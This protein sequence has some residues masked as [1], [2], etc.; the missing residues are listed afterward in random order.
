M[1]MDVFK[2]YSFYR[3]MKA[4]FFS[5]GSRPHFRDKYPRL[6]Y[7]INERGTSAAIPNTYCFMLLQ[8]LG[9]CCR[10]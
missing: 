7:T 3:T 9:L 2:R 5:I 6:F 10:V 1:M 4:H 8:T